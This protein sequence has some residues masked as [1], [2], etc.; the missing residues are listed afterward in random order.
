MS[1]DRVTELGTETLKPGIDRACSI[2]WSMQGSESHQKL[3]ITFFSPCL[4]TPVQHKMF[5]TIKHQLYLLSLKRKQVAET[6]PVSFV[7]LRHFPSYCFS[8]LFSLH[9]QHKFHYNV[10]AA[11]NICI[12]SQCAHFESI[13]IRFL[14]LCFYERQ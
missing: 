11:C 4:W 1:F 6:A 9:A 3:G 14:L 10:I 12:F 5:S 2:I 13:E 7:S 8:S